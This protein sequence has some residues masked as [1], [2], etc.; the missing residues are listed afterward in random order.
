MHTAS[1]VARVR[2]RIALGTRRASRDRPVFLRSVMTPRTHFPLCSNTKTSPRSMDLA[3]AIPSSSHLASSSAGTPDWA[4]GHPNHD[5]WGASTP[6]PWSSASLAGLCPNGDCFRRLVSPLAGRAQLH[7]RRWPLHAMAAC[8]RHL[9]SL[10]VP[11]HPHATPITSPQHPWYPHV[12]PPFTSPGVPPGE[13]GGGRP[14]SLSVAYA[15][16]SPPPPAFTS[17]RTTLPFLP[18]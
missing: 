4:S 3:S 11:L 14:T 2:R 9:A 5:G 13:P 17:T 16:R 18:F 8:R 7:R 12:G 10:G 6:P 15:S 1:P